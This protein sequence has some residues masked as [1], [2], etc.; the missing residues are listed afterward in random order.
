MAM[1][2][3]GWGSFFYLIADA[4]A[5]KTWPAVTMVGRGVSG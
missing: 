2:N 4:E 5:H 1:L 3:E